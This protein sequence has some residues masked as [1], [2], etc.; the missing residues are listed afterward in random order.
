MIELLT[1]FFDKGADVIKAL[2]NAPKVRKIIWAVVAV[3]A[4]YALASL[5]QGIGVIKWW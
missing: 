1:I 5:L 4:M 2:E 3:F